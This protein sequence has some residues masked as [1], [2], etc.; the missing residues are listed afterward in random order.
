[1]TEIPEETA[2]PSLSWV[3]AALEH[4][5]GSGTPAARRWLAGLGRPTAIY[6]ASRALVVAVFWITAA[7]SHQ[8]LGQVIGR[9]D[10][11]WFLAAAARGYPSRLPLLHGHVI[12][13]TLAFFPGLPLSMRAVSAVT[14]L[15]LF[16]SGIVVSSLTGL[17]ATIGVWLLVRSYRGTGVADRATFLFAFFPATFAFSM[18][19]SEGIAITC[20]AF[21]LLALLKERWV[22][23]GVLGALATFTSPIAL[24]FVLSCG[25]VAVGSM[26][27]RRSWRPLAAPL[28]APS[29]AVAYLLWCAAHTGTL[30]AWSRT[31]RDGWHSYVSLAFPV[32]VVAAFVAHPFSDQAAPSVSTPASI[33][34][35]F[36]VFIVI[37]LVVLAWRDHAPPPVLIYGI[38]VIVLA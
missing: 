16:G 2:N 3:A 6:L 7:F 36:C 10:S 14:S 26:R 29:G 24:I 4:D 17:T 22:T 1:M 25:W 37:G 9:W 15:S 18:I 28:L 5:E 8:T 27:R 33:M 30:A 20:V 13:N 19:Y 21:G 31:E 11:K 12:A 38:G 23:A 32:H 34:L 35:F